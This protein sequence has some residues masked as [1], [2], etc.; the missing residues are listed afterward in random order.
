VDDRA[1]QEIQDQWRAKYMRA[2]AFV[3]ERAGKPGILIEIAAQHPLTDG[4]YP[5]DEFRARLTRGKEVF[6][7]YRAVGDRVEVYVPGSRHVFQG[8]PD[9]IS[10]SEAGRTYLINAGVPAAVIR[11]EDLN[12]RYK[13]ADGVYGSA[14]ECFVAAS[15]YKDA[16][17]G[18]LVSVLSPAQML[19]KTLHYIEFGV[20]PLN[21]TAPTMEGFHDYLD[22]LF[23]QIPRVLTVDS[24]LQHDSADARRLREER[25]PSD[26]Q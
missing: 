8:R 21:V 9:R 18:T 11:G 17:F 14:D 20:V 22:E 1:W 26:Q 2:R 25:M 12:A 15:Y 6:D 24:S 5:N 23:E 7:R 13:G 3:R 16:G 4:V 10:L 19:R